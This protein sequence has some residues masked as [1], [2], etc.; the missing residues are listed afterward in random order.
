MNAEVIKVKSVTKKYRLYG[1]P[2]DRLKEAL[3]PFGKKFHREFFAVRNL[4]MDIPKGQ[5]VGIIGMNGSGKSTILQIIAGVLTATSGSAEVRG[6]VAALLE[7]GGGFNP[8]FTGVENI[9]FQCSIMGIPSHERNG[10]IHNI[11]DFA[12]IGDFA[13]QPV[14]TYSSGM[15]VRLA[16]SVAAN[17]Q[18]DILIVDEALAVG[19]A[20]FQNKCMKRIRD[21]KKT[22]GTL[23]FVSHDPGAVKSLCDH[24]YLLHKGEVVDAGKPKEVFNHYNSLLA[25]QS[26]GQDTAISMKEDLRKRSGNKKITIE[27]V[28]MLNEK[29][30]CVETFV[31]GESVKIVLT[32]TA[33][34][35]MKNPTIG[36]LIRDLL[37]N[38]I[39]GTNN[40]LMEYSTGFFNKGEK[41][42]VCY[43][44]PLNLGV[45][46]Y[47]LTAALHK[48]ATHVT[49]NF[50]W[51]NT[52]LVFKVIP[53]SK[54]FFSGFC[55]MEAN[56]SVTSL[57]ENNL[58]QENKQPVMQ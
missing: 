29:E 4:C 31:S 52:I 23:L 13:Y 7:L 34:Y 24:A 48:E 57:S 32:V 45:N 9:H 19:D 46:T 1:S 2:V 12:E 25:I 6:R 51:V 21:F 58:L 8:E 53:S 15:Y 16:F 10:F 40:Y 39:F 35:E 44:M 30:E 37:G 14:R 5:C 42:E 47:S 49:E 17:V 43:T 11:L 26:T 3:H 18:P 54:Q 20:Y 36:I 50:D 55:R 41:K 38:D 56:F 33:N 22:G 28:K 27:E